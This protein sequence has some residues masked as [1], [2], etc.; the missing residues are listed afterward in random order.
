MTAQPGDVPHHILQEATRLFVERGYHG[1]SMRE[2]A[3]A[4][5]VSKAGLYYY[6]KDK[7]DLFLA[8]LLGNLSRLEQILQEAR[9]APTARQQIEHF[10]RA[11]FRWPPEERAIIRLASQEMEHLSQ[12]GVAE[13]SRLYYAKF[14]GQVQAILA[15]GVQ[16]GELRPVDPTLATWML[17]G[18]MYPFFYSAHA[19]ARSASPDIVDL[20]L[21]IFFEGAA[22]RPSSPAAGPPPAAEI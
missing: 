19:V 13:F 11:L 15:E 16:R 8:I 2:I 3:E 4:V 1:L 7:E 10:V 14:I 12:H 21:T 22:A 20:M 17:L 6:F 9:Q 5:G 18:M